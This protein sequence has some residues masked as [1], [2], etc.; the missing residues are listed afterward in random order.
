MLDI[1]EQQAESIE[2][3]AATVINALHLT[4]CK[5]QHVANRHTEKSTANTQCRNCGGIY[6]HQG[7]CPVKG[8]ECRACGKPNHYAEVCHSSQ[9]PPT[10]QNQ[11]TNTAHHRQRSTKKVNQVTACS[12]KARRDSS[13]SDDAHVYVV[14][15]DTCETAPDSRQAER[16]Q[17]RSVDRLRSSCKHHQ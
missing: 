9:R 4:N 13:S 16:C 5:Q 10:H 8:K 1:Y 3:G 15:S 12:E 11:G 7:D 6:P 2:E 14:N 17:R